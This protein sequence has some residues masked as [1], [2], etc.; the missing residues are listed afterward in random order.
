M[1]MTHDRI[2][3]TPLYFMLLQQMFFILFSARAVGFGMIFL[4]FWCLVF[5]V[6]RAGRRKNSSHMSHALFRAFSTYHIPLSRTRAPRWSKPVCEVSLNPK[7]HVML[8]SLRLHHK[9]ATCYEQGNSRTDF[10]ANYCSAG[11]SE[12]DLYQR[13]I[14]PHTTCSGQVITVEQRYG[15][16]RALHLAYTV[17]SPNRQFPSQGPD[18]YVHIPITIIHNIHIFSLCNTPQHK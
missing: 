16:G 12:R 4:Q 11:Y 13:C 2:D 7:R 8:L 3:D 1:F 18:F 9:A 14:I 6:R 15:S 17:S 5:G 10:S